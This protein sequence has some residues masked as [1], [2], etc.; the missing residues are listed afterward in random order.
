MNIQEDFL[1][2]VAEPTPGALVIVDMGGGIS[3]LGLLVATQNANDDPLFVRI[4]KVPKR[5][6]RIDRGDENEP[7][8]KSRSLISRGIMFALPDAVFE[9][10]IHLQDMVVG[11]N[12]G[13]R[14][15]QLILRAGHLL[16]VVR[17]GHGRIFVDVK[18]GQLHGELP[19]APAYQTLWFT[20]WSISRKLDG[21]RVEVLRFPYP[22]QSV[23]LS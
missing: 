4:S 6:G 12:D 10:A 1:P 14:P 21:K 5:E 18:T 3:H 15:G 11:E 13:S 7:A 17:S 20:T 23:P 9:P 2:S 19:A 16:L 22:D 8:L